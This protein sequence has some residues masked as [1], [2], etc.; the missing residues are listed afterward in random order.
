MRFKFLELDVYLLDLI[1]QVVG[2]F[3]NVHAACAWLAL[4]QSREPVRHASGF[5]ASLP[6]ESYT[7]KQTSGRLYLN[8]LFHPSCSLYRL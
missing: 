5:M 8:K 1:S 2:L 3:D 4:C 7:T 6:F